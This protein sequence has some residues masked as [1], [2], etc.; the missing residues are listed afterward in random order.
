MD[1]WKNMKKNWLRFH[2]KHPSENLGYSCFESIVSAR[3]YE[4]KI[5]DM[6]KFH[7][8]LNYLA[9]PY[10]GVRVSGVKLVI[11]VISPT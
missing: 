7:A 3:S 6:I 9:I 10:M 11:L 2:K 5:V 8:F 4:L 1:G